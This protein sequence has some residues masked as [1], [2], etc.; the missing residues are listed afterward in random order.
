MKESCTNKGSWMRERERE[1]EREL[2]FSKWSSFVYK[3]MSSCCTCSGMCSCRWFRACLVHMCKNQKLLFKKFCENTCGWK[4]VWKY[5]KCCLKTENCCLEIL[6]KHPLIV[7]LNTPYNYNRRNQ[8]W[9]FKN[10]LKSK[11]CTIQQKW[12]Y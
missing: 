7:G 2:P 10:I 4:S 1:R 8:H 5:V 11:N 3:E 9:Y 6:T 12:L